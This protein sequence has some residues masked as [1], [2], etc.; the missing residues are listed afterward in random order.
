MMQLTLYRLIGCDDFKIDKSSYITPVIALQGDIK[1]DCDI[2]S[3][4]ITCNCPQTQANENIIDFN[5]CKITELNRYYFIDRIVLGMNNIITIYCT[6][7]VLYSF[8]DIPSGVTSHWMN[9]QLYC[10]RR[11]NGNALI[12][13]NLRSFKYSKVVSDVTSSFVVPSGTTKINF[14]VGFA[15]AYYYRVVVACINNQTWNFKSTTQPYTDVTAVGNL[16]LLN[17]YSNGDE[18]ATTYYVITMNSLDK[19][20]QELLAHDDY[21]TYIKSIIVLPYVPEYTDVIPYPTPEGQEDQHTNQIFLGI[22]AITLPDNV[23]F[24]FHNNYDRFVKEYRDVPSALTFMDYAPYTSIKMYIPYKDHIELNLDSVRGCR[25]ALIYYVNYDDGSSDVILY[26][27]TKNIIE[28]QS[29]CQLGVKLGISSTNQMEINNQ[30][31]QLG[32]TSAIS[33]VASA[34]AIM[35]GVSTGNVASVVGGVSGIIGT[36]GKAISSA[37]TMYVSGE[38]AISSGM[39]GVINNQ[40][41]QFIQT[42]YEMVITTNADENSY[43]SDKGLPFNNY[44]SITNATSNEYLQ[45]DDD[46]VPIDNRM[47]KQEFN[48][49]IGLLKKGVRK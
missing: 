3:P 25:L 28:Y 15:S 2:S 29:T 38:T 11:T 18:L 36:T 31:I 46:N 1:E 34:L 26:N 32:I 8:K 13:D 44:L 24:L 4:V 40:N 27:T 33:Y 35:G 9:S 45:F 19:L 22:H 20:I 14:N 49:L 17:K 16:P 6:S 30:K 7:D 43:E 5:Y 23:G 12:Q 47:T 39:V 42:K 37:S 21:K 41:V 10:T 48:T